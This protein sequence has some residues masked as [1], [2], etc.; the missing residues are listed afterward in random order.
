MFF[1]LDLFLDLWSAALP[2]TKLW[3]N[4]AGCTCTACVQC[5]PVKYTPLLRRVI[6]VTRGLPV[7]LESFQVKFLT[8]TQ[9]HWPCWSR[10]ESFHKVASTFSSHISLIYH[11]LL[12]RHWLGPNCVPYS[13][14]VRASKFVCADNSVN[15]VNSKIPMQ[16]WGIVI[17]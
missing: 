12:P 11:A 3:M 2:L 15:S 17:T 4:S 1:C 6:N 8:C 9:L 10:L 16:R 5:N 14:A 7:C 13:S